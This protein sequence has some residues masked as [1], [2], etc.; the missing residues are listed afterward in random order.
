MRVSHNWIHY[1]VTSQ[2][3][4]KW[5]QSVEIEM[6]MVQK[7][8]TNLE[9]PNYDCM[10]NS[11]PAETTKIWVCSLVCKYIF[12]NKIWPLIKKDA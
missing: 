10:Y 9:L 2:S 7:V 8:S 4:A 12:W 5:Y 1:P 3:L 6:T 11:E